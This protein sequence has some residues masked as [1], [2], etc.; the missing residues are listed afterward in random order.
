MSTQPLAYVTAIIE[1]TEID[2]RG[3]IVEYYEVKFKTRSG[4]ESSFKIPKTEFSKQK[5]E[6]MLRKLAAELEAAA[7]LKI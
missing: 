5:V 4:I 7:S 2:E 3:R 1:R 6:E